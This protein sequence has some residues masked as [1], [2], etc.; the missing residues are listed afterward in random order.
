MSIDASIRKWLEQDPEVDEV[1]AVL[2]IIR[3]MARRLDVAR[4]QMHSYV[5]EKVTGSDEGE[6]PDCLRELWDDP[7]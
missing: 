6:E 5:M 1:I 4:G 2:R 7:F 3:E